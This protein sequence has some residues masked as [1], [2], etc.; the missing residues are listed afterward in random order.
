MSWSLA[1]LKKNLGDEMEKPRLNVRL[2]RK[3][4]K[5]ILEEPRRLLMRTWVC[6]KSYDEPT[7]VT[8]DYTTASKFADCGTAACIAG[9]TCILAG[10]ERPV[11]ISFTAAALLGLRNGD[12]LFMVENWPEPYRAHYRQARSQKARA[13]TAAERIDHFIATRGTDSSER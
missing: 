1:H 6:R 4:K 9:W 12:R 11:D 5:H 3:V 10:E 13:K 2:L 8:D 7:F